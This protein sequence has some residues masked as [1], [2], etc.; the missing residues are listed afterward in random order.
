MK[1]S[2]TKL[3]VSVIVVV[4]IASVGWFIYL[5]YRMDRFIDS[6]TPNTSEVSADAVRSNPLTPV[7]LRTPPVSEA[8]VEVDSAEEP[9]VQIDLP[10]DDSEIEEQVTASDEYET[11]PLEDAPTDV[12]IKETLVSF[13]EGRRHFLAKHG[14]TPEAR[15]YL[16]LLKMHFD[17]VTMT[18]PELLEFH[19]LH[20]HYVPVPANIKLY[21]MTKALSENRLPE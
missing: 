7:P 12:V 17:Q 5:D 21:E 8:H 15:R 3:A 16:D 10:D 13:E 11:L 4:P 9:D 20:A 18:K 6:L 19:R 14:D 2:I 1:L